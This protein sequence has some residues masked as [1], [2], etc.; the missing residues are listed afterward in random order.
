MKKARTSIGRVDSHAQSERYFGGKNILRNVYRIP[1]VRALRLSNKLMGVTE[2]DVAKDEAAVKNAA[3]QLHSQN[4]D[5][6]LDFL[7]KIE[8][9]PEIVLRA[10]NEIMWRNHNKNER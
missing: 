7:A 1:G 8:S 2:P 3:K 6:P 4:T 5:L 9:S 10:L